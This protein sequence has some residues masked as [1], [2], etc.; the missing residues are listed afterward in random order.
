MPDLAFALELGLLHGPRLVAWIELIELLARAIIQALRTFGGAVGCLVDRNVLVDHDIANRAVL[1]RNP[2]G[3]VGYGRSGRCERC[4]AEKGF[5]LDRRR[6]AHDLLLRFRLIM[7]AHIGWH[8]G[9]LR[10]NTL[11]N[12]KAL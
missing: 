6:A 12:Q 7:E 9:A 1:Q 3:L 4:G 5:Y 2:G 8:Q 11:R 10:P